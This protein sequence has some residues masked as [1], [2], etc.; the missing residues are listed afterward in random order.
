MDEYYSQC[1][2][3]LEEDSDEGGHPNVDRRALKTWKREAKEKVREELRMRLKAIEGAASSEGEAATI[4]ALLKEKI[5]D[6][7]SVTTVSKARKLDKIVAVETPC[8]EL[9]KLVLAAV[10]TDSVLEY[11]KVFEAMMKKKPVDEMEEYLL[12]CLR[13]NLQDNCEEAALRI[14]KMCI[15]LEYMKMPGKGLTHAVLQALE[16]EGAAYY[17][18][19]K[20]RYK[21]LRIE[22]AP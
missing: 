20:E 13:E 11:I 6:T 16:K 7:M 15:V 18:R 2:R 10:E 3:T 5:V 8:T 14:A 21:S 19:A 12:M 9:F 4:R 1:K 22:P 17:E